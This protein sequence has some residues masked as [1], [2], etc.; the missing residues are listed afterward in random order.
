MG[1]KKRDGKLHSAVLSALPDGLRLSKKDLLKHLRSN[2]VSD[3][4]SVSRLS[5]VLGE[6]IKDGRVVHEGARKGAR[7]RRAS[8]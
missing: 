8:A 2:G 5:G 1:F 4:V 7:F 6:L 3:K